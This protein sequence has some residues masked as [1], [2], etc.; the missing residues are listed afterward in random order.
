MLKP[1][2]KH[3]FDNAPDTPPVRGYYGS[4]YWNGVEYP[5]EDEAWEDFREYK[6]EET[7]E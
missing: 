1:N 3:K 6:K 4:Y 5:T 2:A 7:G